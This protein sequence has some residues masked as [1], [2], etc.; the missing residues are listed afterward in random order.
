M[1]ILVESTE[2]VTGSSDTINTEE[3]LKVI[4]RYNQEETT[5]GHNREHNLTIITGNVKMSHSMIHK[6]IRQKINKRS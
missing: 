4:R 6:T 1:E 2:K 5:Y 3:H